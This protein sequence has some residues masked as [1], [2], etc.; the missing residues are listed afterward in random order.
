MNPK[1]KT[2]LRQ[3]N[4]KLGRTPRLEKRSDW[5]KFIPDPYKAVVVISSDFELAWA[6]RYTRSSK[7]PLQKSLNKARLERE[8]M[9]EIL[10]L[11]NKYNIPVTWLTVG[12][13][14]LENC[15]RVNTIAHPELPR[16]PHFENDWWCFAG[17][18]WF[19][20]DPCS[21]YKTDPLWYCPD[22]VKDILKSEVKHEIGC[23]TFSHIDCRDSVCPPGLLR[24]EI[25]ACHKAAEHL[26][27]SNMESFVHP[28]HT[29]G[30]L[31]TLA[32]MG[33]TSYRTDYANILGFPRKH[34]NGLWEF[35]TTLELEY[36]A[37][38]SQKAQISRYITLLKRAIRHNTTAY[39]WFHPSLDPVFVAHIMPVVFEWL[40]KHRNEIWIV[41]KGEYVRWLNKNVSCESI[42]N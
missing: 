17:K 14:F 29:I 40:D 26:G 18:D 33:F 15:K 36:L 4:L 35:S 1:L 6:W 24:A 32:E 22:L 31:D 41:N 20:Y 38:W 37:D 27:I 25:E 42:I 30:N 7:D 11:C 10:R 5:R 12:H 9:P 2:W 13:L 23:H 16:L 39:L 3:L 19:E 21:D 28:G 34:A 8:N